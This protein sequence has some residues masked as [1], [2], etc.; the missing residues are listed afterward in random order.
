MEKPPPSHTREN[1]LNTH[2][3]GII[4][5]NA[6]LQTWLTTAPKAETKTASLHALQA[7]SQKGQAIQMQPPTKESAASS[8][9]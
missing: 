8:Y 4:H 5:E 3:D 2:Q 7:L 9:H 1:A 6:L